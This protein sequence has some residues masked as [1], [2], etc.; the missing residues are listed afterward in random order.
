[1]KV[2]RPPISS[3]LPKGAKRIGTSVKGKLVNIREYVREELDVKDKPI[4]F[5]VGCTSIGNA[6]N[7]LDYTDETI[8]ISH[9]PLSA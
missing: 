2:I 3:Y 5:V 1:M 9:Y 6:A 8:G 4:V 7:E